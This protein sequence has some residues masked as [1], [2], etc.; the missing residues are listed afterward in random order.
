LEGHCHGRQQTL[1]FKSLNPAI[2]SAPTPPG[3]LEAE[4][5]WVG[6]GS[7]AYFM[8]REVRGKAVLIL[9]IL[10]PGN[11]G[12]SAGWEGAWKR[13]ADLGAAAIFTIWGYND[14]LPSG[15]V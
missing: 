13:A 12:E 7:T 5:V 11:M 14:N 10:E 8:G 15:K 4:E 2:G 1:T 9:S 3:G 6:L